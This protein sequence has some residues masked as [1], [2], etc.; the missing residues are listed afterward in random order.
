MLLRGGKGVMVLCVTATSRRATD[1]TPT[2]RMRLD[3]FDT[4]AERLGAASDAEKADLINVDRVTM[5][6]YR[7]GLMRPSLARAMAIAEMLNVSLDELIERD[8]A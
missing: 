6:R 1:A 5:W 7:K 2:V 4:H 8:A 3:V